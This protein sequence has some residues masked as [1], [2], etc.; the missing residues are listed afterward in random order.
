[1]A[2]KDNYDD[3][4]DD[5][6][7]S[8]NPVDNSDTSDDD[9]SYD[10]QISN[11]SEGIKDKSSLDVLVDTKGH[12]KALDKQFRGFIERDDQWE[13][14]SQELARDSFIDKMV[15]GLRSI[16]NPL[17]LYTYKTEQ[18]VETILLEKN[19]EFIKSSLDEET[20]N[21]EDIWTMVN[22]YDHALETFMGHIAKGHGSLVL[23]DFYAGMS[24]G[25]PIERKE[26][27]MFEGIG[28]WFNFGGNKNGNI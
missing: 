9:Y 24:Q 8:E 13:K 7:T 27:K 6:P 26:K 18:E 12:L 5:N 1:M 10:N 14:T 20:V 19:E 2:K 3:N 17:N 25:Q 4:D 15:G 21:E 16:I 23:R 11:N 22:I 28:N